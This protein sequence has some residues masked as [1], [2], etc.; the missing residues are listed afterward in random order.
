MKRP[1]DDP[2]SALDAVLKAH[3]LGGLAQ[4]AIVDIHAERPARRWRW[5]TGATGGASLVVC[6]H[7]MC[8]R[9]TRRSCLA[10]R[11]NLTD[12]GMCG[13]YDSVIGMDKLEPMRRFI[14]GMAR[15]ASS[16]PQARHAGGVL[17]ETDDR[18]GKASRVR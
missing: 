3:P 9:A 4:A 16:L 7:T 18:T 10:A 8:L 17:V 14:T 11:P 15:R 13:D 12:A 5:A 1:F 6:T 2:F